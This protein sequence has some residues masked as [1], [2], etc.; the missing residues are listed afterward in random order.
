MARISF[1]WLERRNELTPEKEAL[2]DASTGRRFTYRQFN[3]RANRLANGWRKEWGIQKGDRIA[4]LAKNCPEYLES[5]FAAAK[6]GA[7]LVPINI[8]LVGPELSYILNDCRPKGL[9][10]G[11]DFVDV[12]SEVEKEIDVYNRLLLDG[13]TGSDMVPYEEFL[14]SGEDFTP[15]LEEP[16]S[17]DDPHVILYTSGTTGYPKGAIQTHGNILFNSLNANLA[18]DLI[19][20]DVTLCGLPLF[21]TGG[22]HVMTTP[23]IHAG[24]TIVIERAFD[25]GEALGLIHE[26][27]V[28]TIFFVSTMW[29]FMSQHKDF[30][31]TDFS[32]L[33]LAWTGGAPCPLH[34]IEAYQKK[35]VVFRQGYGLTEVGP[36][37]MI[38]PGED[39]VRKAG[40]IGKPPFHSAMRIVDSEDKDVMTGQIGELIFR[41]PTVTPGYWNKPEATA[42]AL[43]GGWFHTG[44]LA[45]KDEDG[46]VFIVDRVKDMII[47]GG[48]NIYPVE[49]EK[50]IYQHPKV[51]EVAV[52]GIPDDKWG[53]VGNAII[54][55]KPGEILTQEEVINFL[56][57]KLARYKIPKMI[58][59]MEALPRNPAGKVL[60]RVLREPYWKNFDKQVH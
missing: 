35:G 1:D 26:R 31:K 7:I 11:V 53:E 24:G 23:T 37:A 56:Q 21:H 54:C 22:L 32:G 13:A 39:A 12:I 33:R 48:E 57:N 42:E 15:K 25:A 3:Q 49:I 30:Q 27:R 41:G 50:I 46:Y 55:P 19:S 18:L 4:I 59:F 45:I 2:V 20:S 17:L 16:V 58:T 43:R 51:A 40:S 38:L 36:D 34:V 44:D 60:K 8:R 5:L 28:N 47:S 52:I 14:G 6:L 10:I 29:L 9:I